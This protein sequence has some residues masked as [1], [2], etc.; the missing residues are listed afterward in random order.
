MTKNRFFIVLVPAV[1]AAC[2]SPRSHSREN[3]KLSLILPGHDSVICYYG[4]SDR[5]DDLKKGK[6]TDTVFMQDVLRSARAHAADSTFA[7]ALKPAIADYI[8]SDLRRTID[9]LND[10]GLQHRSLDTLDENEKRKFNV[11]SLETGTETGGALGTLH[12][13]KEEHLDHLPS[14][15]TIAKQFVILIFDEGGIYAYTGADMRSGR[16][17]TYPELRQFL[18][19]QKSDTTRTILIKAAANASYKNTVGMLDVM[20]QS[21]IKKYALIDI[22]KEEENYLGQLR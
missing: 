19:M 10:N 20:Q 8:E 13:P 3:N 6:I 12:L 2:Q 7:I 1:F 5:M 14:D 21:G 11:V 16:K 18:A 22:S 4:S 9:W 15:T 17:Y